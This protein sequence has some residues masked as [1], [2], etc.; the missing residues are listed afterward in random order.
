MEPSARIWEKKKGKKESRRMTLDTSAPESNWASQN[1]RR[2]PGLCDPDECG[3]VRAN[4]LVS[5]RQG[6]PVRRQRGKSRRKS[7]EDAPRK[8]HL[9]PGGRKRKNVYLQ[10]QRQITGDQGD[11][12]GGNRALKDPRKKFPA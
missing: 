5:I 10:F 6:R 12:R 7:G 2:D 11:S 3:V 4:R 1:Q 8:T 9:D